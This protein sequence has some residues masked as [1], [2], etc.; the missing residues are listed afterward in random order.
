MFARIRPL[1]G[2][3]LPA[4]HAPACFLA[5]AAIPVPSADDPDCPE[6]QK[7]T[8]TTRLHSMPTEP[9][10]QAKGDVSFRDG[11]CS[12][13]KRNLRLKSYIPAGKWVW[14]RSSHLSLDVH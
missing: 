4:Q 12:G 3:H 1:F 7:N 9:A 8:G 14:G 13:G 2:Q 10:P 11:G 6:T 5:T